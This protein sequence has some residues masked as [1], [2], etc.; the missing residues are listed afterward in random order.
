VF[1]FYLTVCIS[2]ILSVRRCSQYD[3]FIEGGLGEE[4]ERER[5]RGKR[6]KEGRKGS[7]N[8]TG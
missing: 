3:D 1:L 5:R 7:F 8:T 2:C 4:E 6:R